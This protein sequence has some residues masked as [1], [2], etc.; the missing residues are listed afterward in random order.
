MAV[1]REAAGPLVVG[2]V[3]PRHGLG[4]APFAFVVFGGMKDVAR[5]HARDA[6]QILTL[7]L[8]SGRG[9]IDLVGVVT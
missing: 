6:T 5:L 2:R 8:L 3:D 1:G 9:E 4:L 7:R